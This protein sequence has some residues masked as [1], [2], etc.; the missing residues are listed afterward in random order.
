MG[1]VIQHMASTQIAV[2]KQ[3]DSLKKLKQASERL[4]SGYRINRAADDAAGL[5][6]SEK[7]RSI[8]RGL[9]QGLRNIEDG[10]GFVRTVEGASQEIH[11]MLHRLK[12]LAVQSANGTYDDDVDREALDLE[13]QQILDEIDQMTDNADFNGVPLFEKHLSAFE[14][15]EAMC[16]TIPP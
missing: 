15:N 13:Y 11:N 2:D 3:Q 12:E 9:R 8:R 5:A 6:V 10:I 16:A 14:M 7:L 1:M 4:S